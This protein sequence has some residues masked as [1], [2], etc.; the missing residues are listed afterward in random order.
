MMRSLSI[1]CFVLFLCWQVGA[2]T[3]SRLDATKTQNNEK[4]VIAGTVVRLDT[5]EPLKRATVIIRSH[6]H[7]EL[8][9]ISFAKG[10]KPC[11]ES[12]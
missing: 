9:S 6:D 1:A 10:G 5:G 4:C 7:V 2:Q 12:S 11:N 8:R 3:P